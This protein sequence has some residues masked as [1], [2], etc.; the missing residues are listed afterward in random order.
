MTLEHLERNVRIVATGAV[1][2]VS[3]ASLALVLVHTS[4][5]KVGAMSPDLLALWFS[6]SKR[7][8]K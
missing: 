3:G 2:P 5:G 7:Y 8:A 6:V 4:A 1:L